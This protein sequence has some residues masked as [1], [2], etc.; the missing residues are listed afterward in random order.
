M[1]E[2]NKYVE[3]GHKLLVFIFNM[4]MALLKKIFKSVDKFQNLELYKKPIWDNQDFMNN[5]TNKQ[6]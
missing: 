2:S 6:L 3:S 4:G 5:F 1:Q